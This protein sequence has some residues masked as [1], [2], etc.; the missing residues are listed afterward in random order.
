MSE[1]IAMRAASN[2]LGLEL[3]LIFRT[4]TNQPN[5]TTRKAYTAAAPEREERYVVCSCPG[6]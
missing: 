4:G 5:M 6:A 3:K 1:D 2:K